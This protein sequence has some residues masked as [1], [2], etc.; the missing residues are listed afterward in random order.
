[1]TV[2]VLSMKLDKIRGKHEK[3]AVNS[4]IS[5]ITA[6]FQLKPKH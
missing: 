2:V 3:R 4:K 1:M 6:A 5:P